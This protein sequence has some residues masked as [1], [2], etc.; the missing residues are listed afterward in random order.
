MRCSITPQV[1]FA[2]L[3]LGS[4]MPIVTRAQ[5][6]K[7]EKEAARSAQV[8]KEVEGRKYFMDVES[9]VPQGGRL[10]HLSPGYF[11]RLSGDSLVSHLPYF[12]QAYS[13]AGISDGGYDFTS[14]D[15][16][17]TV[18]ERKKGG[19]DI[20]IKTKD[21]QQN[22]QLFLTIF[23]NGEASLQITSMSRQSISYSGSLTEKQ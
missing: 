2:L 17:Y 10:K 1:L 15:F 21:L 14:T 5:S 16:E 7:K 13:S 9:A 20:T 3:L 4:F 22:A 8:Q 18:S 19:W 11:L 12:G 6:S 23:Q